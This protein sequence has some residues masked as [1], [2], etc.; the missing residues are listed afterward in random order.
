V[1]RLI[2]TEV[3]AAGVIVTTHAADF[4]SSATDFAVIV[5]GVALNFN[6]A[7]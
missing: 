2:V 1:V 3:T 5:T 6:T 7:T 4:V